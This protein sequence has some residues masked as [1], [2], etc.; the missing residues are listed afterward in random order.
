MS[1]HYLIKISI[2]KKF[3][4]S[5]GVVAF[6]IACNSNPKTETPTTIVDTTNR[7]QA[8]RNQAVD[9]KGVNSDT[10]IDSDGQVYIKSKPNAPS[11]PATAQPMATVPVRNK[12]VHHPVRTVK[13]QSSGSSSGSSTSNGSNNGSSGSSS[14]NSG[15][16]TSTGSGTSNGAGTSTGVGSSST[17]NLV[18]G[19]LR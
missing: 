17:G 12:V 19:G 7:I 18:Q 5:V 11:Q 16:G 6:F 14:T 4:F 8:D 10:I 2:M 1:K 13:H 9:M 3:L 15:S